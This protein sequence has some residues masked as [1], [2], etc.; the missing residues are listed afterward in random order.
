MGDGSRSLH[1]CHAQTTI[2]VP[3]TVRRVVDQ[4]AATVVA[5]NSGRQ[6]KEEYEAEAEI[7]SGDEGEEEEEEIVHDSDAEAALREGA[8]LVAALAGAARQPMAR[9]SVPVTSVLMPP[10]QVELVGG[11]RARASPAP[12][13]CDKTDHRNTQMPR[14]LRHRHWATRAIP[15]QTLRSC[16]TRA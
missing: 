12:G 1:C 6:D 2:I 13:L 11:T 7:A 5:P 15:T 8:A 3:P 14:K 16:P 10:S 9:V 4:P